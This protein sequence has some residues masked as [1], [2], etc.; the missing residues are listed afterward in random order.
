MKKEQV[1]HLIVEWG[2]LLDISPREKNDIHEELVEYLNTYAQT[3]DVEKLIN[4][5][6]KL[7]QDFQVS[8]EHISK[9]DKAI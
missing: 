9:H 3:S 4:D 1:K 8:I 6:K 2:N 7:G 5:G